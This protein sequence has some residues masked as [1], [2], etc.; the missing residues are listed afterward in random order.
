[1]NT[2]EIRFLIITEFKSFRTKKIIIFLINISGNHEKNLFLLNNSCFFL[3]HLILC[4]TETNNKNKKNHSIDF[5]NSFLLK[6]VFKNS[7]LY[8]KKTIFLHRDH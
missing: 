7:D 3:F 8:M 5:F 1:M 2:I 4:F 6:K